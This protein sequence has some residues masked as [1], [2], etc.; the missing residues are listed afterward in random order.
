MCGKNQIFPKTNLKIYLNFV[1]MK[2][3]SEINEFY[4]FLIQ[5]GINEWL[6]KFRK[7]LDLELI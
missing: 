2:L 5:F 1:N 7:L 3:E 6:S 4:N